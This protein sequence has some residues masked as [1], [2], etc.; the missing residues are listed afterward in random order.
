MKNEQFL[1]SIPIT[2]VYGRKEFAEG[3]PKGQIPNNSL[4]PESAYEFINNTLLLDCK[5]GLNLATFCNEGY[6]EPWGKRLVHENV[7]INFIDNT[8]YPGT[9]LVEKRS[10]WMLANELG[11]EF[12]EG[13]KDP[14][15]AKG[16][17]GTATIGSS[18]AIMLGLIAHRFRWNKRNQEEL[19]K[20]KADPQDQ[21]V[22]L[23]SAH[24]HGCW[25]KYCRYYGAI[26][27]YIKI[28]GSPY[29]I[30]GEQV[31]KILN[32]KI[33][34]KSSEYAKKI[35]EKIGYKE[36]QDNRTIGELVMCVGAV[37]GS[38]FTGSY[39]DVR[40][41]D[42]AVDQYCKDMSEKSNFDIPIHVDAAS[43]GFVLLF[44][45]NGSEIPFTFK[46]TERV[47]S[48][49]ISNH[50]FGMT[51]T[52]MGSVIFRN[53]TVVDKSLIYEVTYVGGTFYDY[54]VNF[55]RGSNIILMQ[56]YNF[57]RFGREGYKQIINNCLKNANSFITKLEKNKTLKKWLKCISPTKFMPIIVL[58]WRDSKNVPLT[59]DLKDI[60]G[61]LKKAGWFVPF[62]YLPK[63]S[64]ED[65]PSK[66][67]PPK[68]YQQVLRIVV[69]QYISYAKLSKL[70]Y[71]MEQAVKKLLKAEKNAESL[72]D[73]DISRITKLKTEARQKT[74]FHSGNCC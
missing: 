33:E 5:P 38:T 41:I 55:S 23:M 18:E 66:D 54:T 2:P 39:D 40:G 13:D 17:Y 51:F 59:W 57:I 58:T 56:Y 47:Q 7:N 28:D 74:H 44:S 61:E 12:E 4:D 69:Q 8:E 19:K 25:D 34:D 64:P 45:K 68:N 48:I 10:T 60:E 3:I 32:T 72:T 43:G 21:P 53:D 11:T 16:F 50:K 24:V 35:R 26:S 67:N 42:N 49:N 1:P 22:V 15:K 9:R 36:Y 65:A 70:I 73:E 52:G 14:D 46:N 63:I 20:D 37:V 27:L 71:F 30:D 29:A 6:C 31:S 62:Y